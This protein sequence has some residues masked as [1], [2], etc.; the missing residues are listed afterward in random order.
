MWNGDF[1]WSP[2]GLATSYE[3]NLYD[4]TAGGLLLTSGST[5]STSFSYTPLWDDSDYRFEVKSICATGVGSVFVFA[6]DTTGIKSNFE[7]DIAIKID[8]F[9]EISPTYDLYTRSHTT[10]NT[11]G[12]TFNA[13]FIGNNPTVSLPQ[14]QAT[15]NWHLQTNT[16]TGPIAN[17]KIYFRLTGVTLASGERAKVS[18][19][20]VKNSVVLGYLL[21]DN[22]TLGAVT[23]VDLGLLGFNIRELETAP[24]TPLEL[25][26]IYVD[27]SYRSPT[28]SAYLETLY[29]GINYPTS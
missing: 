2:V 25:R 22:V 7:F 15:G 29:P 4:D 23:E 19:G 21:F 20:F 17:S 18:V 27:P 5:T 6:K 3:Y 14:Q 13:V 12:E 28:V 1:S 9:S 8:G 16:V 26:I 11:P 10:L 24:S